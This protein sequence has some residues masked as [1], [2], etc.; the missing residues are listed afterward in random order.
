MIL[1]EKWSKYSENSLSQCHF[2]KFKSHMDCSGI[3]PGPHQCGTGND[4]LS[5]GTPPQYHIRA[6]NTICNEQLQYKQQQQKTGKRVDSRRG[7]GWAQHVL[8]DST[9]V[10]LHMC[11]FLQ[12]APS[13]NIGTGMA[14][15]TNLVSQQCIWKMFWPLDAY[16]YAL[17]STERIIMTWK[18][19]LI[20]NNSAVNSRVWCRLDWKLWKRKKYSIFSHY[21]ISEQTKRWLLCL[22]YHNYDHTE[23]SKVW[24]TKT[25]GWNYCIN[26][27]IA[28]TTS[29]FCP[30]SHQII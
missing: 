14:I 24:Y 1:T 30:P 13:M 16:H 28:S 11:R 12:C 5:Y 2:I 20:Y 29:K 23:H 3:E 8:H 4:C 6:R 25:T 22:Q 17:T 26:R 27:N 7:K 18:Y 21:L 15:N 10:V 19:K 9:L